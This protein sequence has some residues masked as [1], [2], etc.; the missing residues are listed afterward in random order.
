[1][2]LKTGFHQQSGFTLIEL[3]VAITIFVIVAQIS[4]WFFAD[5]LAKNRAN[6][7][8]SLLH[9]NINFAR[10][11]AIEHDSYVTLCALKDKEC[12]EDEWHNGVSLFIDNDRSTSLTNDEL[13]ISTFEYSHEADTLEYPR[14]AITFRP[15]GSLNGFQ[16]GTFVYC[17]NS[18]DSSLEGLALTISQTGRIRIKSTNKCQK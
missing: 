9:R 14:T 15:D 4:V 16:N 10:L 3:M 18:D 17:P 11:Y 1:M 7:Q 12:L 5:F 2:K 13:I 8:I 6:N